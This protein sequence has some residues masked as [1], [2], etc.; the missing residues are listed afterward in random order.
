MDS[1]DEM[2]VGLPPR[3]NASSSQLYVL[4]R[5]DRFQADAAPP[6]ETVYVT[7]IFTDPTQARREAERLNQLAERHGADVHYWVQTAR[8]A[9]GEHQTLG[10]RGE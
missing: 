6:E 5:H 3:P 8:I 10:R 2:S 4:L 9:P 1:W 7:T